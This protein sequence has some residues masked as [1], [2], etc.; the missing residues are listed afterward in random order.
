MSISS[1][2]LMEISCS[3]VSGTNGGKTLVSNSGVVVEPQSARN[4]RC[5]VMEAVLIFL[6][7]LIIVGV[8][9]LPIVFFYLPTVRNNSNSVITAC[10]ILART[11][12]A[13]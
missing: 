9:S 2:G 1:S 5:P 3:T 4:R 6:T 8:S 11:V 12:T 10:S 7:I 13:V